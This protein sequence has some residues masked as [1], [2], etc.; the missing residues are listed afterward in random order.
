[1]IIF[2]TS[3]R[4]LQ[5]KSASN[6]LS[7]NFPTVMEICVEFGTMIIDLFDT[8]WEISLVIVRKYRVVENQSVT[9]L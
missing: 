6:R 4:K 1:M 3:T 2:K 8:E 5:L 7:F 9:S